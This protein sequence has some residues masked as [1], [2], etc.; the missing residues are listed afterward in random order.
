M[1]SSGVLRPVAFIRTDVSE[2]LTVSI[3]MVT[4]IGELATTLAVTGNRRSYEEIQSG[5]RRLLVTANVP[6]SPI[7][8]T[9]MMEALSFSET[10]VLA[11]ATRRNIPQDVIL[12]SHSRENLKCYIV[13]FSPAQNFVLSCGYSIIRTLIAILTSFSPVCI[14]LATYNT[15]SLLQWFPRNLGP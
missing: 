11:R 3:I 1:P 15:S 13:L 12:H 5:V 4:R 10:S 9:L 7:L 14:R 6:S 8:V 2:E